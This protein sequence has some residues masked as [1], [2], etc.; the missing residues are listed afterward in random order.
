MRLILR[1]RLSTFGRIKV[2]SSTIRD[3]LRDGSS[4][5]C[6]A[7]FSKSADVGKRLADE[8]IDEGSA[9]FTRR[10][11]DCVNRIDSRRTL[12]SHAAEIDEDFRAPLVHVLHGGLLLQADR[13]RA[14]DS[15][16]DCAVAHCTCEDAALC[17]V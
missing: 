7:S 1:R 10:A 13:G 11:G 12:R 3:P 15:D 6:T 2:I 9:E 4:Q 16:R 8:P 5:R 17:V 14:G